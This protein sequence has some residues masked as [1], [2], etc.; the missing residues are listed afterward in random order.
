M[1][2]VGWILVGS[3]STSYRGTREIES[4]FEFR[5]PRPN[6]METVGLPAISPVRPPYR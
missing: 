5:Y 4:K 1:V 2:L 6:L 3:D